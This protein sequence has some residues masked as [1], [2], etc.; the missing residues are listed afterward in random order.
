MSF[1]WCVKL[2][3]NTYPPDPGPYSKY[4]REQCCQ[5]CYFTA[6]ETSFKAET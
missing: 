3:E 2:Y 4:E 5:A 1:K 6:P